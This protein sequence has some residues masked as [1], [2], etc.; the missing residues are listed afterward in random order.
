M[1]NIGIIPARMASSRLPGKPLAKIHGVPMVGHVFFRSKM[2]ALLDEVYVATC[3]D[4]IKE[5]IESIGG[6]VIMTS[7]KHE[8]ASDRAAEAML[9]IEKIT[10]EKTNIVVM[11]QGDEPMLTPEMI[12]ES[13]KPMVSD[14]SLQVLNLMSELKT[15]EEHEDPN[16]VKVVVDLKS[17]AVYFSREPIPSWKKGAKNVPMLKQVCIIPFRR[18]FLLKFNEL[19][20]TPLEIIESV[21][22]LRVLEHG[23]RVKMVHTD[24]V[25]YSVDT[26]ADRVNVEKHMLHDSIRKSYS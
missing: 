17:F 4:E 26:E 6:K 19:E 22:M 23:Y 24:A 16:E 11:I 1:K 21:D 7:D 2:C 12:E 5:Y 15:R 3:D 9:Q 25:S 10:G 18:D 20:P 8:R 14:E 13:I